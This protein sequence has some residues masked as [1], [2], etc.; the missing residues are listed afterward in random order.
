[1]KKFKK[2]LAE[3]LSLTLL[4][5]TISTSFVF[6][7]ADKDTTEEYVKEYAYTVVP[8]ANDPDF[9]AVSKTEGKPNQTWRKIEKTGTTLGD[10][11]LYNFTPTGYAEP[12]PDKDTTRYKGD[13]IFKNKGNAPITDIKFD[14]YDDYYNNASRDV[15]IF[16][17]S[18]GV[19][20]TEV[21]YN[22][23]ITTELNKFNN[24]GLTI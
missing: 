3:V 13:F 15:Q 1:M 23:D 12:A 17:S 16:Y 2:L 8:D 6:V 24:Q 20:Y 9:S 5:S 11:V 22:T 18:D 10:V 19:N 21:K 14:G 4:L 7:N